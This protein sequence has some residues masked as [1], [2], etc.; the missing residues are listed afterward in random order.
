M[1]SVSASNRPVNLIYSVGATGYVNSQNYIRN[2]N[3]Y[4]FLNLGIASSAISVGAFSTDFSITD[5]HFYQTIPILI[6]ENE[7]TKHM[8]LVMSV[9]VAKVINS[10]MRL[11]GVKVPERM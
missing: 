6:E 8:R 3:F 5:N 1:T 10:A 2:N 4:D 11:L 7:I 9:N